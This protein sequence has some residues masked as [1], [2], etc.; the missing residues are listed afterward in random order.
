M[1]IRYKLLILILI[2]ILN[3]CAS[4][5]AI[6]PDRVID[7]IPEQW[8]TE[9]SNQLDISEIWWEEFKDGV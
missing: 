6:K 8:K 1:R 9:T 4:K 7:D 3:S 5:T 2:L